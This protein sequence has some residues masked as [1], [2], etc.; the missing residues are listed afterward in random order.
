MTEAPKHLG[1]SRTFWFNVVAGIGALL[2]L[3]ILPPVVVPYLPVAQAVVNIGLRLIT[4]APVR[5]RRK[6]RAS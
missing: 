2:A 1:R 3:P 6:V 4:T 5:V